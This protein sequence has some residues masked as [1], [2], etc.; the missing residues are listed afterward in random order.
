VNAILLA[1][2]SVAFE[3]K[4]RRT[5]G[6]RPE[7]T[8]SR[9]QS[10][11]MYTDPLQAIKDL[12]S[13]AP[14]VVGL[15]PGLPLDVALELATVIEEERPEIATVLVADPTTSVWEQALRAGVRAVVAPD[16]D[17]DETRGVFER[18]LETTSRRRH[19]LVAES[20]MS[21]AQGRVITLVAPKGGVGKTF[22]SSNLA[23]GLAA[24]GA[25]RVALVDLDLQFGDIADTL[26]LRPE[27]TIGDL[28]SSVGGINAT[29]LKV[30]LTP[31]GENL[32]VLAA[33]DSPAEG[34]LVGMATVE[35]TLRHLAQDFDF[36]IVDTC[37]GLSEATLAAIEASTDLLFLCDLSVSSLRALRKVI[38]AIDALGFDTAARHFVLNRSDMEAGITA[39]EASGLVGIPVEVQ[40]PVGKDVPLAM[41]QGA[42]LVEQAPKSRVGRSLAATTALFH[43][44]E[45]DR[46]GIFRRKS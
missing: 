13:E 6:H 16:A 30:F 24:A 45:N 23:V 7:L 38:D 32:F 5:C 46:G 43:H 1:T 35:R 33:P 15:G 31:R 18:V 27:H 2:S 12:A 19:N 3:Q 28:S 29:T 42:V 14:S 44:V 17:D 22:L 20:G 11:L 4:V 10:D 9:W 40:V 26:A 25:G 39:D 41:N 36:V 21:P 34:E 8:V 37:A